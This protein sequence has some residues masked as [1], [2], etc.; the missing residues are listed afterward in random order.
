MAS[1][2]SWQSL[3][4]YGL[5]GRQSFYCTRIYIM[6]TM[7]IS[8]R[9]KCRTKRCFFSRSWAHFSFIFW[10]LA[11]IHQSKGRDDDIGLIVGKTNTIYLK[12]V[13]IFFK[14]VPVWI[15][16]Y[17]IISRYTKN[18]L[19]TDKLPTIVSKTRWFI[20]YDQSNMSNIDTC[21]TQDMICVVAKCS[22]VFLSQEIWYT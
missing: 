13:V 11:L 5:L 19:L 16:V 22:Q 3:I 14:K 7:C 18:S 4:E 1:R 15:N 12:T 21:K 17:N 2:G 8:K 6:C 10:C 20:S 9:L